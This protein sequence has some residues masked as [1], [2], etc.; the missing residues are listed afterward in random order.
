M[1]SKLCLFRLTTKK[2][3]MSSWRLRL[4]QT[5]SIPSYLWLK[6]PH[7][8]LVSTFAA[9]PFSP[10]TLPPFMTLCP[11]PSRAGTVTP[12]R[13]HCSF[14]GCCHN[15]AG[16][17]GS[18]LP[19]SQRSLRHPRRRELILLPRL[20]TCLTFLST[21]EITFLPAPRRHPP[22]GRRLSLQHHFSI[23]KSTHRQLDVA[24]ISRADLV[25][26]VCGQPWRHGEPICIN[27]AVFIRGVAEST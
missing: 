24:R 2:P 15:S 26:A 14:L 25:A 4:V 10:L 1:A 8:H 12:P 13:F 7:L 21:S 27:S 20:F 6:K 9:C 22:R 16:V 11:K 19:R 5:L 18:T 3:V 23:D 17:P